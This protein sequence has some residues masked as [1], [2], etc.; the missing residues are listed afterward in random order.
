MALFALV[1]HAR[2]ARPLA[3]RLLRSAGARPAA[4]PAPPAALFSPAFLSASGRSAHY[5]RSSS[6]PLTARA[7]R[8]AAKATPP[9][10]PDPNPLVEMGGPASLFPPYD[11]I[12]AGVVAE[13][14]REVVRDTEAALA[15]L[16]AGA[17]P[18]WEGLVEPLE[19]LQEPLAKAWGAVQHLKMVRDSEALRAA[20]EEVQPEVVAVSLRIG[21]SRAVADAF[22]A[23]RADGAQWARL[24]DAQRRIV[25]AQILDSV[26]S[27]GALEGERQERF[28]EIQQELARLSTSFGNN[29]LD[30]TKAFAVLKTEPREVR[31]L[32]ES[33]LALAA[34]QARE[35][36]HGGATPESGPWL[37]TLDIPS[38][39]AVLTYAEDRDF[40]AAMY[41]AFITRASSMDE[42]KGDNSEVILTTLRLRQEKA[43]LLGYKHH[44]D[45]SLATKMADLDGA[46][47]LLSELRENSF[48]AAKREHEE[49]QAFAEGKGAGFQLQQW[50]TGFYAEK[51]RQERYALDEEKLRV[52]FSLPEVLDGL[53]RLIERLFDVKVEEAPFTPPLWHESVMFYQVTDKETG[54][55]KAYFYLDPY[56][57]PAEK[58]GGAW[59]NTVVGR[60]SL[61]APPGETV[62][63]PVAHMVLNQAPPVDGKPSLMKFREVETLFHEMGH[64][65]Q[66]MLTTQTEGMVA[67]INNVEWDA[68]E[69]PSQFMENWLYDEPTLMGLA[70]HYETK[71]PMP[72]EEYEKIKSARTFRSGS[73]MARQLH[74]ATTDLLLHSEFDPSK[75]SP[76]DLDR[77]VA[78]MHEAL[79][80]QEYDRFLNAFSHIFA[81]GYSAG[82]YS[83]KWA[84]VLSA[85]C[86]AAF[87]EVGLEDEAKVK[88]TGR[89]FR[90]TILALGGGLSPM[91]VFK[92]FRG[93]EP[94]VEPLLRHS[95]LVPAASKA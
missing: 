9:T 82:Y 23:I 35:K 19:R 32:P 70:K 41:R 77:R 25:E 24:S 83:Y 74:F 13:G 81:G 40:R 95:G 10:D 92:A 26:L 11:R 56:T 76:Y 86:F 58:R 61:L 12:G 37:F 66:H 36:G 45:V 4:C 43:E 94:S 15:E 29:V 7:G 44:A 52:Y 57:R 65:L 14:M 51:L 42:S 49:L 69:Q 68:V 63:L 59:M 16:E 71:E 3:S 31:G 5:R 67:G 39:Q 18:S 93:R 34:Q 8:A 33:A 78:K 91:E 22:R 84:E 53:I 17:R 28:N 80:P 2:P 62:R 54:K 50:D 47:K 72:H 79:E 73:V 20:V 55:A 75:E 64:A 21:Q 30:A 46:L 60:S 48:D 6:R 1:L 87:E 85:D 90:D 27:G 88:E 89:R 38:Y